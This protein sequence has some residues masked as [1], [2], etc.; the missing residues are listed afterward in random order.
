MDWLKSIQKGR[1]KD[2]ARELFLEY[3][4]QERVSSRMNYNRKKLSKGKKEFI[5]IFKNGKDKIVK[6]RTVHYVE[7]I[8]NRNFKIWKEKG[9]LT[10]SKP[11]EIEHQNRWGN[12][13]KKTIY[14]NIMNLNPLF[15]YCSE[16]K[17]IE[18]TEEEK[19]FLELFL[20]P[21]R[22]RILN[23]FPDEDIINAILKFYSS[24]FPLK[25]FIAIRHNRDFPKKYLKEK[26]KAITLNRKDHPLRKQKEMIDSYF[27][28]KFG[29]SPPVNNE[30]DEIKVWAKDPNR[31]DLFSYYYLQLEQNPEL[32]E[33]VD[34][35]IL[36][37][38]DIYPDIKDIK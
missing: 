19:K 5:K 1:S 28:K 6:K 33:S 38:L 22:E 23:D 37:A 25:Y 15:C 34:R 8:V 24:N 27:E 26:I 16:F 4:T 29:K 17:E 21:M 30:W 7:P 2:I 11:L 12:K 14:W 10:K 13:Q 3:T 20:I 18:F 9:F 36:K 35:K 31:E 32:I